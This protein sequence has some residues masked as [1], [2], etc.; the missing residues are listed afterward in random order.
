M[1]I[2]ITQ[3]DS[4]ANTNDY[5]DALRQKNYEAS[6]DG[7]K[8]FISENKDKLRHSRQRKPMRKWQWM[9]AILLPLVVVLACT[10]TERT[11]P[12]GQTV[13]FSVPVGDG[14]AIQALEPI[15]GGLQTII[16]PDRQKPGY[17]FYTTFIP[18]QSSRSADAVIHKLKG[19]TGITG[20]SMVPLN[21]KVRESLLSRLGSKIF[22]THVDANDLSDEEMQNTVNRQLK[23]Q[24][25][26]HIS[27]TV[28]RN[29]KG[30]R[31]L[32]LQAGNVGPNYMIDV[33]AD[34]N[35]TKMVLKEENGG[36]PKNTNVSSEPQ[37]D[38]GNMTN[39]EV[40]DYI[41]LRHGK[42]LRD[43]AIKITRTAE[44]IAISITKSDRKEEIMRFRL[45]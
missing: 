41:R 10:R 31:T 29:E 43:E 13:S 7:V 20:L 27:V 30:V 25:F 11:E 6:F 19:I 32:Q 14:A 4:D 33:S 40:R 35:G 22:S 15:V 16:S 28:T 18:A 45:H 8:S 37:P 38:F 17:L 24:G 5:F 42:D 2:K 39:A 1:I 36:K 44:E 3:Q 9:F 23:E 12:V 26:N 21:T 34:D